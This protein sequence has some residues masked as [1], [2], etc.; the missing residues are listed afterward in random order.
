MSRWKH[1]LNRLY[2]KLV[3]LI[4]CAILPLSLLPLAVNQYAVQHMEQNAV[5]AR[6]ELLDLS[7]DWVADSLSALHSRVATLAVS[8]TDFQELALASPSEERRALL[9]QS[10]Y[11]QFTGELSVSGG[12]DGLFCC[13][14]GD[15]RLLL[16]A[17][18]ADQ[19]KELRKALDALLRSWAEN[20]EDQVS[21]W[22][23]LLAD[24]GAY[25]C[26]VIHNGSYYIG[27]LRSVRDSLSVLAENSGL[28][29][30]YYRGEPIFSATGESAA[31]LAE[32]RRYLAVDS[33][34]LG[35]DYSLVSAMERR[36]VLRQMVLFSRI[37]WLLAL[38]GLI[39]LPTLCILLRRLVIL[40]LQK[41]LTHFE[42]VAAGQMD[43]RLEADG[44]PEEFL[45]A[46]RGFNHM[47]DR[48]RIL[49]A[50]ISAEQARR[51][52]I[53][54][55][56]LQYQIRPHFFLNALNLIYHL[57]QMQQM[58]SIQSMAIAMADYFRYAF[59]T[60]T[61]LGPL[62]KELAFV[63]S[64][65][66][67]QKIRLG[68]EMTYQVS[69]DARSARA[70][71][72]VFSLA[73]YVENA[74]KHGLVG[75]GVFRIRVDAEYDAETDEV[76]ITIRDNGPGFRPEVLEEIRSG[77]MTEADD[78]GDEVHVGI[79]NI[80]QTFA[81]RFGDRAKLDYD[82]SPAGGAIVR[83]RL[84]QGEPWEGA[85]DHESAAGR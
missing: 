20:G 37:S 23:P 13:S 32:D 45:A 26:Y 76:C 57:A 2:V 51:Q 29:T 22:F 81:L 60:D 65:L 38:L 53:E 64:Y 69:A 39:L 19:E 75:E 84:Q 24:G 7:A 74:F 48:I 59:R 52:R 73:T 50:D 68:D 15:R 70:E 18:S 5:D 58:E 61:F 44:E 36:M 33:F 77:R 46:Y 12:C 56:Q 85:N 1:Y 9:Y 14:I 21:Q 10:L 8:D 25:F 66:E 17:N 72:P 34:F 67:I 71:I 11:R 63:R 6:R 82:N 41:L 40:P 42:G 27:V 62:D 43:L 54:L 35:R 79:R 30:L 16:A 49:Q 80:N 83:I 28:V 31:K 47:M 3:A 4:F 78:R 55:M